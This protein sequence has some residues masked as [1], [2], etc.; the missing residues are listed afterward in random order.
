MRR[1]L[2]SVAF[3]GAL[4]VA[5]SS[6]LATTAP[7]LTGPATSNSPLP[8]TITLS[9]NDVS[10][11]PGIDPVT[12]RVYRST[13][14]GPS[15]PVVPTG[16]AELSGPMVDTFTYDDVLI[17]ASDQGKYCYYVHADDGLPL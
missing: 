15:C 10:P 12:Y 11:L 3:A 9:W 16:F 1:L 2:V 4:L 7:V 13:L 6:A 5:P 8:A 14:I 17:S